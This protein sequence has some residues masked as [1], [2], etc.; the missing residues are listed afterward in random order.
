MFLQAPV[1]A[2]LVNS[3]TPIVVGAGDG[4]QAAHADRARGAHDGAVEWLGADGA[5]G[6]Q[7]G[8]AAVHLV[9]RV[10]APV[11]ALA[12][13][14]GDTGSREASDT[15]ETS[16]E[17]ASL[18]SSGTGEATAEATTETAVEATAETSVEEPVGSL[19]FIR[20]GRRQ[21]ATQDSN[22]HTLE[23]EAKC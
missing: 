10:P 16:R 12:G 2:A 22:A 21:D 6:L 18:E 7:V 9:L 19:P 3:A 13:S 15:T 4:A 23:T 11:P 14:L 20:R 17:A 5:L 8:L 1:E